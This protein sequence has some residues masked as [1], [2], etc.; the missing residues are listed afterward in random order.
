M[1]SRI[2]NALVNL[3]CILVLHFL[4]WQASSGGDGMQ[5]GYLARQ[6]FT[7]V[8]VT[9]AQLVFTVLLL[10][11][12]TKP[13]KLTGVFTGVYSLAAL[14]VFI[15]SVNYRMEI[16]RLPLEGE[17]APVFGLHFL[18][19]IPVLLQIIIFILLYTK[20]EKSFSHD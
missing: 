10:C 1:K 13:V 3:G 4:Y 19:L 6:A 20:R 12:V 16:N 17:P 5:T 15:I 7:L 11:G 9:L 18:L 8:I 2:I 14:V